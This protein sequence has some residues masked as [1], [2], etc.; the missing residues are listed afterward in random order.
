M[1]D[2]NPGSPHSM[3][4]T[5]EQLYA[6]P[7]RRGAIRLPY[8]EDPLQFAELWLPSGSKASHPVVVMVH[9]GCWQSDIATCDIM[10]WI[11]GDLADQGIAVWNIEY[12]GVDRA[13][14]GY[15]G[16]FLDVASAADLLRK[17]APEYGLRLDR[18]VAT[19]HSAGGHLALWLAARGGLP[20]MSCLRTDAPLRIDAVIASGALPDLPVALNLPGNVCGSTGVPRLVG[21]ASPQ[22]PDVYADTCLSR[23][24]PLPAS[25]ELVYG[26]LDE[27]A[28]PSVGRDFQALSNMA[29]GKAKFTEIPGEAH[30]ELIAPGTLAWKEQLRLINSYLG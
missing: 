5:W 8:G 27:I 12:R 6:I 4:M 23:L 26:Q 21:E 25:I 13:G 22:R 7:P 2:E 19:G 24:L 18:V 3:P 17:I 29:G 9:G 20:V 30:V 16:T 15:P 14:G 1:T 10:Q 28:P 11:A